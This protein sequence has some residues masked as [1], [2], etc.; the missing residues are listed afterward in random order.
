MEFRGRGHE[1]KELGDQGFKSLRMVMLQARKD[2]G[3]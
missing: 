3:C 2:L 1:D